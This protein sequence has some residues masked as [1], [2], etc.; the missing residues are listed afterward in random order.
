MH[1]IIWVSNN[2]LKQIKIPFTIVRN[3]ALS[4]NTTTEFTNNVMCTGVLRLIS[5][6]FMT[7]T[8]Y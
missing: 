3:V 1:F 2:V 4:T 5:L 8:S 7:N 6:V